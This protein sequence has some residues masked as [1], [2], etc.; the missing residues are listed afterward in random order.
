MELYDSKFVY[1]EW[2]DVLEGK[3]V[4]LADY[5]SVLKDMVNN[6]E[7]I[8]KVRNND[9]EDFPFYGVDDGDRYTF[10]YY[11]P[12]YKIKKAYNEGKKLQWKRKDE[13]DWRDWDGD[14][15]PFFLVEDSGS[16]E[17]RVKPEWYVVLDEYGLSRTNSAKGR[18][19]M[20]G[21]TE[22]ECIR[23]YDEHVALE[24]IMLAWKQGETIQ[25][26]DA[27][28]SEWMDIENPLWNPLNMYR[29]KPEEK[30]GLYKAAT[31]DKEKK[32]PFENKE[33]LIRKWEA[34]NPGC[35]SRP[36]C[37]NPM[38]WVKDDSGS[39]LITGYKDYTVIVNGKDVTFGQLFN[40]YTFL[41][42]TVIGKRS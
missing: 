21:G 9:S 25:Y 34:M 31:D 35:K 8:G 22:N 7:G 11:D 12:N 1:F 27:C 42:G 6:N 3:D 17:L 24:G 18:Y 41:D 26:Y 40:K 20:F 28:E 36:V 2:D 16:Y 14:S 32:V 29:V 10:A 30:Y 13:E 15:S 23:W 5:I 4:F 33:E 39:Y 19:V 38:I 37:A